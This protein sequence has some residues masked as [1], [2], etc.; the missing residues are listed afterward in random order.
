MAG[1]YTTQR[2]GY[3]ALFLLGAMLLG[4]RTVL[5]QDKPEPATAAD[6]Q[7][8]QPTTDGEQAKPWWRGITLNGFVSAA[9]SYNLNSPASH[10]NQLRV[11]DFAD[12]EAKIDV[13]ELVVQHPVSK[14]REFGFR[15]DATVG[16]SIPEVA[17][18]YG[19]FRGSDGMAHHVDVHQLFISYVIPVKKGLRLDFGKFVT[20]M[21]AEV[22]EGYDG[23]NDNYTH[24]FSFGYGIPYTHTGIR[25]AY[26]FSQK[27]SGMVTV[28]QGWD[29][30]KDNNSAKSVGAQLTISPDSRTTIYLNYIGGP[31]ANGD[32]HDW[33]H[34]YE[35]V[36]SYKLT[37]KLSVAGD[38]L[39]G[40]QDSA[41][42]PDKDAWWAGFAGYVKRAFTPRFSMTLRGEV[43]ADHDGARTG[44]AQTLRGFTLTPAYT[45]PAPLPRIA[46]H[47]VI[48]GDLRI[49]SSD[50]KVFQHHTGYVRQ[51]PTLGVNLIYWF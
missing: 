37:G 29:V 5:C 15:V 24:S 12:G 22:I 49:D 14:P 40:S 41:L 38:L 45:V 39:H 10:L 48:R 27:I 47:L 1:T 18:S 46:G 17:E 30:V 43:F 21:G 26:A 3:V 23:Y 44:T 31:E 7:T 33:R 34:D 13:A 35:I 36:G 42:G 16:S 25:A 11:F 6:K 20:H 9:Y 2:V 50:K 19:M 51:Q 32:D 28:N 8:A 4:P